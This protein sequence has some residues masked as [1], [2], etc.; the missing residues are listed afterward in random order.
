MLHELKGFGCGIDEV[1]FRRRQRL[2]ANSD[3]PLFRLRDGVAER[4]RGPLPRLLAGNAWQEV[5]LFGGADDH[6]FAA[7]IG[8]E[9]HQVAEIL[10]RALAEAAIR[11]IDIEP[12]RLH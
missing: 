12:F 3:L 8:A 11:V 10:C 6:H 2:E 4:C 9:I 5:A 1:R 7:E